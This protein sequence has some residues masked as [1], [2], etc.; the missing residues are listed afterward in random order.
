LQFHTETLKKLGAF[1]IY[2]KGV[3]YYLELE[4]KNTTLIKICLSKA[5]WM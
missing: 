5:V 4:A 3:F 2:N 1:L